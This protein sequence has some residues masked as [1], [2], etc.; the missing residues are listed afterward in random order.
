MTAKNAI[1]AARLSLQE[2]ASHG[3]SAYIYTLPDVKKAR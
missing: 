2:Y 1:E 3:E